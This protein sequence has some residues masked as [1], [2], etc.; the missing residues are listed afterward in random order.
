MRPFEGI[1]RLLDRPEFLWH[2]SQILSGKIAKAV[3]LATHEKT[4]TSTRSLAMLNG[5]QTI[6]RMNS[7]NR[8]AEGDGPESDSVLRAHLMEMKISIKEQQR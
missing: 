4:L 6:I 8:E 2:K 3:A 5:C 1:G 7:L